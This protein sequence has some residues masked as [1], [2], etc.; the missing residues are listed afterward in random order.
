MVS[1][2]SK[3]LVFNPHPNGTVCH[4]TYTTPSGTRFPLSPFAHNGRL[5][6]VTLEELARMISGCESHDVHLYHKPVQALSVV[7]EIYENSPTAEQIRDGED[8]YDTSRQHL[9]NA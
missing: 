4:I 8:R 7:R 2:L 6:E 5:P 3:R 9:I 1:H